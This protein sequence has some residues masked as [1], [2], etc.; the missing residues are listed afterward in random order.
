MSF[1]HLHVHTEYSLLDGAAKIGPLVRAAKE[2]GQKAIAITDHGVMYGVVDFYK[3]AKKEG[4]KPILGCEVYVAPRR[5]TDKTHHL[6]SSSHHLV[7]LC[8]NEV[9]YR[10]LLALVSD[11]YVEG[12]YNRPRTDFE[13]LEQHHEGLIC[14]S[15][16]LAG[17]VPQALLAGNYEGARAIALRYKA[18]F[19]EDYYIEIQ[20]HGLA[21]QKRIL[22]LLARLAEDCGIGLV[23]TNDVHYTEK[24]DAAAQKVLMAIQMGRTVDDKDAPFFETQEFYLKSGLEMTEL[25]SA[26][27]GAIDN[28]GRIAGQCEVELEFG[29]Y[30]LPAFPLPEGVT[31]P[32]ALR[33]EVERGFAR[34][35]PEGNAAAWERVEFELST[36]ETMGFS[37]YFLIV[38]DFI[39]HSREQG[40]AVGPGRGSAAGSLVSYCLGITD[41]DPL[42][43]DLLFERF[44]NPDRVSMP[45]IDI[46]F[47]YERRDEV[48]EYVANK[49]G[50]DHVAQIVT[51]GTMLARGAIRDT[52]RAL[53]IPYAEVD[54]VAKLVP[55]ELGMTLKRALEVSPQL[56]ELRDQSPTVANL[57][58]M[59]MRL[60]GMPRHS[61]IHAAGVVITR[62]PIHHYVP[63]QKSDELLVT[64]FPMGTLE[65]LGLLKMDFLGLRTLTLIQ[66]AEE[67]IRRHT[68]EFSIEEQDVNDPAVYRMYTKGDTEGVFQ[69]ESAGMRSMLQGMKPNCFE[70]IV[71]AIALYRPGP[72]DSIPKYIENKQ[73]PARVTYR[74]PELAPI[75]DVT[76]GCI[77]YQEQVMA[78]VRQLAGF[79]LARAD[80]V[81]RAMSKKKHEVMEKEREVFIH[82]AVREDGTVEVEGCVR[83]GIPAPVASA[84]F[85]DMASF[86]SY[87]FNKS[88]AAAY[89]LVSYRTAWLKCYYPKEF[90]AA[91]LTTVLENTDKVAEHTAE[92]IKM[93]IPVLP[94]DINESEQGFTVTGDSIRY[95]LVAIKGIGYHLID[96][97]LKE[98]RENGPFRSFS[99]FID[100]T[101]DK[102]INKKAVYSLIAAGAF[103]RFG[104]HRVQLLRAFEQ[105]MDDAASL[106]R[107]NVEGQLDLFGNAPALNE[108]VYEDIPEML[109]EEKLRLEK[110]VTGFYLSGH[111]LSQYQEEMDKIGAVPL[112][113]LLKV[114]EP[115]CP[116]HDGETV[117]VAAAITAKRL[118]TTRSNSQLAFLT[119]EDVSGTM[120]CMVF[121]STIERYGTLLQKDQVVGIRGRISAREDELLLI[122][123]E[124]WALGDPPPT[125]LTRPGDR[126]VPSSSNP[127]EP[128]PDDWNPPPCDW[129]P[130]SEAW[131]PPPPERR[132]D[133]SGLPP[134]PGRGEPS[135]LPPGRPLQ[136]QTPTAPPAP[137]K[138]GGKPVPPGL[139][140]KLPGMGSR[141]MERL[142]VLLSIFS[143]N[144]P[145]F[146]RLADSGKLVRH[147]QGA[148]QVDYLAAQVA[149]L[150][151]RENVF[152]SLPAA[153]DAGNT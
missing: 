118:R 132:S 87:A 48:K 152:L 44:L 110:E 94:P 25:F 83:R 52:G 107:S 144:L 123:N 54:T 74:T 81:R 115:D 2:S 36:I 47:C 33:H 109:P 153:P 119:L 145:V 66:K 20:D 86:A 137:R 142:T 100:R 89:A 151:G 69:V 9:G 15:A 126:W 32:Q 63:L 84:I 34:R 59:A 56:R 45:D 40:I 120:N 112:R 136:P 6:D 4:I 76:Y 68:P 99:D 43:Y 46:D 116:Y 78:I 7:L 139:Y 125:R 35:F 42:K 17:E 14:L 95:G 65:E 98:R 1:V 16:C 141:E 82:G 96:N 88:H 102:E 24:A 150:V 90:M 57:L 117:I 80:L 22:P 12:F 143:G 93:G 113:A 106:R 60:E 58:D 67:M 138:E 148:G 114:G 64:Q 105:L 75:L 130:S 61:S 77:V 38:S 50:R 122:C 29:K 135:R 31:A 10:N 103:D 85:D 92:C 111:P 131:L 30:H 13:M 146:V 72:M 18:L 91:L 11:A 3:A 5:R 127:W 121:A 23:A 49:Y 53:G 26:Y 70:D 149:E 104:H 73:N 129:A 124:I 133:P 128:P 27:P 55:A 108:P 71:A 79:S 140:L 62:E 97:L 19:G 101:I 21:E 51:F 41:I 28:T 8:K 134:A 37:D 147:P 39:R